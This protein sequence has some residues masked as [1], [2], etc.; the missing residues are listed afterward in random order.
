[1]RRARRRE[2]VSK[3]KSGSSRGYYHSIPGGGMASSGIESGVPHFREVAVMR[4]PQS[5][6][7]QGLVMPPT[8]E[9]SIALLAGLA[10]LCATCLLPGIVFFETGDLS[11]NRERA[12]AGLYEGA[13]WRYQGEYKEFLGTAISPRHFITAVHL[14]K[15]SETFVQRSWFTGEEFDRVYFINPN[16]NEGNGSL[17]IPG[18]DLRIFEVFGEFPAYAGLYTTSDEVGREVVMM[19]RGRA[20]G[21]AVRRFGQTRGWSWA[22][23]DERSRWGTNTVDGFS[24]TGNRGPMLVTDF[25]DVRGRDECQA[26]YG[27]S[28][29]GVFISKGG[30]WKLAGILFGADSVYDT[31]TI[32]GDGS[33]FLAS[34]FDGAG[35]YVGRDDDSCD[36]WTLVSAANDLDESR[37]YASRI[38]SSAP[39]IQAV[40]QSAIEDK[41]KTASQRFVEWLSDF[42]IKAGKGV[43]NDSEADGSPDLLEYLAILNPAS[44]DDRGIPFSVEGSGDKLLFRVRARLDASERGLSWEIQAAFN[45]ETSEF[46]KVNGLRKIGQTHSLSE[47]VQIVEY[48]MSRPGEDLMFYRLQVRL[49]EE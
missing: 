47:G 38:S 2:P 33:E 37:S 31:N 46:R 45:L 20:R 22:P 40:I 25:D 27:D 32:C 35:F 29:G 6:I 48:E 4:Q 34:M 13:G 5:P 28:G 17:D 12:P 8:R 9:L 23:E 14:G 43:V 49:E 10:L 3:E 26:T 39:A 24:E 30:D 21:E 1:M 18:T 41:A 15:G 7:I 19:G 36:D 44:R 11:H 42:G 16:F